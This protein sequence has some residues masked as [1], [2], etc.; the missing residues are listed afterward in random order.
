MSEKK[1][2]PVSKEAKKEKTEA[3][4]QESKEWK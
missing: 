1:G 4:V 3:A 2:K